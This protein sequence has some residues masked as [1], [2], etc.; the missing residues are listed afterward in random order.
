M[1][2]NHR[3][4]LTASYLAL[5][6]ALTVCG[7]LEVIDSYWCGMGGGLIGVGIVQLVRI[8]RYQKDEEYREAVDVQNKDER[9]KFLAGKAW[10]WAGYLY[11][12][13]NGV[14]V[15]VLRIAGYEELSTWAAYS[16]C[17][18]V[19]LYWLSYLFLQKKY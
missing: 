8:I 19:V 2:K 9:N 16:V 7:M 18:V 11:V 6:I 1:K 13:L 17:L 3:I 4:I 12:M 10:A 14:A 5:G 15:V